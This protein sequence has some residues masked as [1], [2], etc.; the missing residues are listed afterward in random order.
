MALRCQYRQLGKCG[1]RV[2]VPVIGG[3]SYGNPGWSAL[4]ILKAAWDCGINTMDTANMYS[5][6]ESERIVGKFLKEYKIPRH[7]YVIISK[8]RFIVAHNHPEAFTGFLEPQLMNKRDYVNQ[9]GLSRAALFNQV[10]A[11]LERLGTTYLDVLIIH[12]GD[13]NTPGEETM[14]ALH[15]LVQTGKVRYIGASN[16]HLWEFAE[17]N[18]IAEKNHWT[19][20]S[21]VQVEHSL[22]YRPEEP[23]MLAYCNSKG[24]GILAYS[25]LMDGHLARPIGTKSQRQDTIAGTFLEKSRRASDNAIIKRIE[26]IAKN[27][28]WSMAQVA[29]AWSLTRVAS[30]VVGMNSIERV[31]QAIVPEESLTADE[32]KHLEEPYEF[33]PYRF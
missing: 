5:N 9:G 7:E 3:M 25:P 32:V 18:N 28:S 1:L 20:F 21:C 19:P 4:P 14:K 33:Q 31:H 22:I 29:L 12:R 11:S 17:M 10:E 2:S 13:P 8:A 23:E 15:D 16:M 6:G 30:P 26:E 24:I 27:R